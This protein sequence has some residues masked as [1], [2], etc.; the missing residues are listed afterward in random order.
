MVVHS[1]LSERPVY[2]GLLIRYRVRPFPWLAAGWVSRIEGVRPLES[3][4]DVQLQGPFRRWEHLHRFVQT[5]QGILITDDI[6]YELHL[7]PLS[8][9]LHE[10]LV[11]P[12]LERLFAYR[13]AAVERIFSPSPGEAALRPPTSNPSPS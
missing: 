11:R 9:P 13:R 3:F 2:D 8:E 6:L 10:W 1:E 4:R 5:R 7:S 12:R